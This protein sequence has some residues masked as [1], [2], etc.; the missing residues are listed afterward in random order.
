MQIFS[1]ANLRAIRQGHKRVLANTNSAVAAVLAE[2][3]EEAVAYAKRYPRFT[4]RTGKL[5]AGNE[6]RTVRTPGGRILR[7][8]NKV[9]YAAPIDQGSRPHD[10]RARR[11]PH[12]HFLGK[13]GWVRTKR[14]KHP[15]N[16]PYRFLS[17][18]QTVAG[19]LVQSK[20]LQRMS[21]IA[22]SF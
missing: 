15:G 12:L 6:W 22:R 18:A 21:R 11:K 19:R 3:G 9:K 7:L 10:I 2:A 14:V 17:S 16:K 5:Q 4:P 1:D 8:Q 20:L 13:R